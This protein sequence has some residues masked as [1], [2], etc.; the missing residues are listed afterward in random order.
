MILASWYFL[1]SR[2]MIK[3]N[4]TRKAMPPNVEPSVAPTVATVVFG[5]S[6]GSG[7]G[8]GGVD[9]GVMGGA[10]GFGDGGGEG[11]GRGMTLGG[12]GGGGDGG[13]GGMSGG[14]LR[15]LSGQSMEHTDAGAPA[16]FVPVAYRGNDSVCSRD[17][18]ALHV[19]SSASNAATSWCD[20]VAA[21]SGAPLQVGLPAGQMP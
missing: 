17:G 14:L 4:K 16:L 15:H 9:G 1:I 8:G 21:L 10:G 13:L 19:A 6:G 2:R 11:G 3:S 7:G 20:H 18:A 12:D 5:G